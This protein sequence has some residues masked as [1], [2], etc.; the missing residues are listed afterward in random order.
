MGHENLGCVRDSTFSPLKKKQKQKTNKH[1][2]S[3]C[4][5]SKDVS[6]TEQEIVLVIRKKQK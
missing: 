2:D 3:F 6:I 1:E 4:V 5:F